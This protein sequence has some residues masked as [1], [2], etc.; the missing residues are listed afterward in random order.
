MLVD[1]N[2][3]GTKKGYRIEGLLDSGADYC[4][5]NSG[6]AE[7]LIDVPYTQGTSMKS[8]GVEGTKDGIDLYF[9]EID[10]EIKGLTKITT[11]VGFTNSKN[12][13]F[14][15]GRFGFFDRLKV[16]FNQPKGYFDIS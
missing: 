14:L 6:Y 10:I 4:V 3:V 13:N 16:Y 12:V 2:K 5:I 9:H 1:V 7:L 8:R 15:L 11:H